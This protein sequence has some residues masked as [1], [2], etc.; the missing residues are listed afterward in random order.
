[1]VIN[2]VAETVIGH[3]RIGERHGIGDQLVEVVEIKGETESG[4]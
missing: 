1:M 4:A 3:F 2:N